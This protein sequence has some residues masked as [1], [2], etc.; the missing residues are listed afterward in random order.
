MPIPESIS[1]VH[2]MGSSRIHATSQANDTLTMDLQQQLRE[3]GGPLLP[4]KSPGNIIPTSNPQ[5]SS[6]RPQVSSLNNTISEMKD[7]STIPDDVINEL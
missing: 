1:P 5:E 3:A 7:S 4:Y 2:L 6:T